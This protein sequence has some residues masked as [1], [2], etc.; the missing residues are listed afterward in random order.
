MI[1]QNTL[2]CM[3][4]K[5]FD[6]LNSELDYL[7]DKDAET[8]EKYVYMLKWRLETDIWTIEIKEF[9]HPRSW[10]GFV[11][12]GYGD[13]PIYARRPKRRSTNEPEQLSKRPHLARG[14]TST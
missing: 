12:I 14:H 7:L 11:L 10:V 13:E 5:A 4:K 2:R 3:D 6:D 8:Y 1:A 9:C